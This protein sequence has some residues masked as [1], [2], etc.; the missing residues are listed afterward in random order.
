[1]LE[2]M[3]VVCMFD[4]QNSEFRRQNIL[5]DLLNISGLLFFLQSSIRL[6]VSCWCATYCCFNK[7]ALKIVNGG[8]DRM[9]HR[10][11]TPVLTR[12]SAD[13]LEKL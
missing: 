4:T 2:K 1:M 8:V 10:A 7:V 3:K 11:R 9:G 5:V 6:C 13:A 12:I